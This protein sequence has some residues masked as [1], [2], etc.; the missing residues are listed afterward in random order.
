MNKIVFG[1]ISIAM[2]FVSNV[3]AWTYTFNNFTSTP[4]LIKLDVVAGSDENFTVPAH[5]TGFQ[6]RSKGTLSTGGGGYCVRA[7]EATRADTGAT[8]GKAN[9]IGSSCSNYR[10]DI[11][12][13]FVKEE[14]KSSKGG[15]VVQTGSGANA[16]TQ[17]PPFVEVEDINTIF[18]RIY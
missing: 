18:L 9:V 12:A 6:H 17:Q 13:S 3:H 4:V 15:V 10:A 7:I 5:V 1:A 16:G 8:T 2:A 14:Q 11:T